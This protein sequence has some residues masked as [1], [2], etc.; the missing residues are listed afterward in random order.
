MNLDTL[1]KKYAT[2]AKIT[3][4]TDGTIKV[5]PIVE[6]KDH[7]I[8]TEVQS[9]VNEAQAS[10]NSSGKNLLTIKTKLETDTT[11]LNKDISNLELQTL[12]L[13]VDLGLDPDYD[14][15]IS[16]LQEQLVAANTNVANATNKAAA[17]LAERNKITNKSSEEFKIANKIY[18]DEYKKQEQAINDAGQIQKKIT[19]YRDKDAQKAI[20]ELKNQS[21]KTAEVNKKIQSQ[22][23]LWKRLN[24][25]FTSD[26]GD[27]LQKNYDKETSSLEKNIEK[28]KTQFCFCKQMFKYR[29]WETDRKSVV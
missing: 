11:Q 7:K 8:V 5:I 15:V 16:K 21:E 27:R 17:A 3:K 2:V 28:K 6:D 29:D 19:D 25:A 18:L 10:I 12:E 20:E 4:N 23:D 14:K 1:E 22:I 13:N 24:D 26:A 9:A